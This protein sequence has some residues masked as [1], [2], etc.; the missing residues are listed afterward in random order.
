M[1]PQYSE[2]PDRGHF[3]ERITSVVTALIILGVIIYLVIR[4]QPFRDPN[5]VVLARMIL[6]LAVAICGA[7]IPGFVNMKWNARGLTVRAGGALA[8]F[9]ITLAF[10]PKVLPM[11]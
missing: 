7:T 2:K 6:A 5:L 8:L 11:L 3:W 10:T 1:P 4:N 9:L